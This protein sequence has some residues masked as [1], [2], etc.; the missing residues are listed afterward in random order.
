MRS[1]IDTQCKL[2][3]HVKNKVLCLKIPIAFLKIEIYE[4]VLSSVLK[5]SIKQFCYFN[6]I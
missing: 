3:K 4:N 6:K 1:N 2:K 5:K